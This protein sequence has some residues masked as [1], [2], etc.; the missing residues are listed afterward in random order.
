M[1]D[2]SE[3]IN[4]P[5]WPRKYPSSKDCFWKIEVGSRKGVKIAF[6][7]LDLEYDDK[8]EADKVKVKGKNST[9]YHHVYD[10]TSLF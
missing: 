4:S 8:C 5:R 6:M 9:I 2:T 3:V 10:L 7:D 1:Y